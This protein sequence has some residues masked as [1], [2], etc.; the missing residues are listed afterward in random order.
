VRYRALGFSG[1]SGHSDRRAATTNWARKSSTV[2]GSSRGAQPLAGQSS[3][4]STQRY[5]E[6]ARLAQ[7][8]V[9]EMV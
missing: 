8:Q 6:S 7:R 4:C 3:L 2:G 5:I 1:A 9:V